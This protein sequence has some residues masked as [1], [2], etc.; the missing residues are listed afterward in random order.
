LAKLQAWVAKPGSFTFGGSEEYEH[1]Q[2]L[3][4]IVE[5]MFN[6]G[7]Y[8]NDAAGGNFPVFII[9]IIIGFEARAAAEHVVEFV[10]AVWF[11]QVDAPGGQNVEARAHRRDAQEFQIAI[12]ALPAFALQCGNF[13]EAAVSLAYVGASRVS[14]SVVSLNFY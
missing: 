2:F 11:L 10:F 14:L 5:A 8:E 12:T 3:L 6:L 4:N 7:G 13:E 9:T 1:G